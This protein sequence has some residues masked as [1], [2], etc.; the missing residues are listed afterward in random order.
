MAL[1]ETEGSDIHGNPIMS[2][3]CKSNIKSKIP[4]GVMSIPME[5]EPEEFRLDQ[6]TQINTELS[7]NICEE[8][9]C[10]N[11]VIGDALPTK[12]CPTPNVDWEDTYLSGLE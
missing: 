9:K 3:V 7:D 10:H 6:S 5:E 4:D 1:S 8:S 11:E 12:A 2:E